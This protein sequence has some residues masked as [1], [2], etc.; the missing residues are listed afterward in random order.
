MAEGEADQPTTHMNRSIVITG[1]AALALGLR[2][3]RAALAA[4]AAAVT[5]G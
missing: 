5:S 2:T 3:Y 4:R 1:L